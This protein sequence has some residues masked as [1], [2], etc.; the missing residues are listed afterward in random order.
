MFMLWPNTTSQNGWR[1]VFQLKNHGRS[2]YTVVSNVICIIRALARNK[3]HTQK[4]S[5]E[6]NFVKRVFKRHDTVKRINRELWGTQELSTLGSSYCPRQRG[7]GVELKGGSP[8][9]RVANRTC[10][11]RN[12]PWLSMATLHR[13]RRINAPTSLSFASSLAGAAHW[14][15]PAR[16]RMTRETR[17]THH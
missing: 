2:K 17:T 13:N 1:L 10:S 8:G 9:S 11:Y 3:W 5:A 4:G 6:C 15:R 16:T 7:R 14:S 12:A